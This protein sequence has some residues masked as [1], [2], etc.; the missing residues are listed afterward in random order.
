MSIDLTLSLLSMNSGQK[1]YPL[2]TCLIS[3]CNFFKG[4]YRLRSLS[5][6]YDKCKAPESNEII[7]HLRRKGVE[8]TPFQRSQLP[9][10]FEHFSNKF[11]WPNTAIVKTLEA[12]DGLLLNIKY[13]QFKI[14]VEFLQNN[15]LLTSNHLIK[16][17]SSNPNWLYRSTVDLKLLID[18]LISQKLNLGEVSKLLSKYPKILYIDET[19]LDNRLQFFDDHHFTTKEVKT[20]LLSYPQILAND[21]LVLRK[22]YLYVTETFNMSHE[23]MIEAVVFKY[24][25]SDVYSRFEFLRKRGLYIGR[26]K[27]GVYPSMRQA[28]ARKVLSLPDKSF[29][30]QVALSSAEE[31]MHFCGSF[32]PEI[33]EELKFY[34]NLHADS[35]ISTEQQIDNDDPEIDN[36]KM[37]DENIFEDR[38]WKYMRHKYSL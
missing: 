12:S 18:R 14:N 15:Y 4:K 37:D 2:F 21:L 34:D 32:P 38:L 33:E 13:S 17:L 19:Q 16:I 8:L 22:I 20:V 9:S 3:R 30:S 27:R 25:Y 28:P 36:N 10:Y 7:S 11:L 23:E 5:L 26:D 6:E 24:K 35:F 1:L 29:L 31:F